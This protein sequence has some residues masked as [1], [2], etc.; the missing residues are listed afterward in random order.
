VATKSGDT[1]ALTGADAAVLIPPEDDAALAEA[2]LAV[3]A[4]PALAATLGLAARARA[5][6]FPTPA[7]ALRQAMDIYHGLVISRGTEHPRQHRL[8]D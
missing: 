7:D 2:V 5:A 1:P 3:L 6:A 4:D 8:L